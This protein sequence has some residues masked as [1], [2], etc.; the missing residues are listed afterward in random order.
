MSSRLVNGA[1]RTD[2]L[3]RASVLLQRF[4]EEVDDITALEAFNFLRFN[5]VSCQVVPL[6][7]LRF[8]DGWDVALALVVHRDDSVGVQQF[9]KCRVLRQLLSSLRRYLSLGAALIVQFGLVALL[10]S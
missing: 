4:V 9:G 8:L 5:H 7:V 10:R 1:L 3:M 6:L 2:V